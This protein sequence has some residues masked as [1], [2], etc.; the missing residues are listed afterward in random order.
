MITK[1]REYRSFDFKADEGKIVEGIP[2]V[3]EQPTVLYEV[4]GI[5]YYEVIDKNA[6]TRCD[7]SDV[8]L[9]IDHEGKPAAKT[10]NKTLELNVRELDVFMSA[11]LDKNATGRELYEDIQNGFYDLMSFSFKVTKDSYDSQTRTRRILE[12]SKMYDVSAVTFAAYNQTSI[13]TRS[14][15]E[16]EAEIERLEKRRKSVFMLELKLKLGKD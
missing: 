7:M 11:N 9:V 1:D 14:Y 15:F 6:L 8:V 16:A 13:N 3:F 12:I 5:K 4:D 10:K 2:I